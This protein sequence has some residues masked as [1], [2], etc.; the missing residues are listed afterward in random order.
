MDNFPLFILSI[1]ALI[2]LLL[3]LCS[4]WFSNCLPPIYFSL[5]FFSSLVSTFLSL[6][7]TTLTC[8]PCFLQSFLTVHITSQYSCLLSLNPWLSCSFSANFFLSDP[9]CPQSKTKSPCP[10]SS[11][12][13]SHQTPSLQFP[14]SLQPFLSSHLA[15]L[16]HHPEP[17]SATTQHL[18][19]TCSLQL[20]VQWSMLQYNISQLS[21]FTAHRRYIQSLLSLHFP[22]LSLLSNMPSPSPLPLSFP[23]VVKVFIGTSTTFRITYFFSITFNFVSLFFSLLSVI[24]CNQGESWY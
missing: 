20:H 23:T 18:L 2:S 16:P 3:T 8:C 10:L 14:S 22:A 21:P 6:S 4:S 1:A 12:Q 9:V 19:I 15:I 24:K 7:L 13:R 11:I 5:T 17:V